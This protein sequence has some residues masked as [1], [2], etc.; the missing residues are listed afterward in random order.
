MRPATSPTPMDDNNA[1]R[2]SFKEELQERAR[3]FAQMLSSID[4]L[5]SKYLKHSVSPTHYYINPSINQRQNHMSRLR[6]PTLDHN[7][8]VVGVT[9]TS[10]APPPSTDSGHHDDAC[11]TLPGEAYGTCTVSYDKI[12]M[13]LKKVATTTVR[14]KRRVSKTSPAS[15]MI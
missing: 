1:Q 5:A 4:G 8:N 13:S 6:P 7:Q 3:L 14:R 12:I 10:P 11:S 15:C 2:M 9:T